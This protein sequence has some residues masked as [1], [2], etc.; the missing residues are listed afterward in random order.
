MNPQH[1]VTL[2]KASLKEYVHAFD[3]DKEIKCV[4]TVRD[5]GKY[6]GQKPLHPS[7]LEGPVSTVGRLLGGVTRFCRAFAV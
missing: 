7:L 5:A 4:F 3:D 2:I 1:I 6:W